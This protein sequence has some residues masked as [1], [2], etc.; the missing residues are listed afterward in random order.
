M[1][2]HRTKHMYVDLKH[3]WIIFCLFHLNVLLLW[4]KRVH[5]LFYY[6]I[7]LKFIMYKAYELVRHVA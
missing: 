7:G 4:N 2:I 6:I 1:Y 3:C 5:I